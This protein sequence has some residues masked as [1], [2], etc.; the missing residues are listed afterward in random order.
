MATRIPQRGSASQDS[1]RDRG[2]DRNARTD[3][4]VFNTMKEFWLWVAVV[5]LIIF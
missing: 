3:W 5:T 1:L 4:S 2:F